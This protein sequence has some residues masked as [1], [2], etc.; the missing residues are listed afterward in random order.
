[1]KMRREESLRVEEE[2]KIRSREEER[3]RGRSHLVA[4]T[5]H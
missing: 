5:S 2:K 4:L 1:M 3:R